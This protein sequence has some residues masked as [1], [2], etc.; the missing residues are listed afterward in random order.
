MQHNPLRTIQD[1]GQSIWQDFIRRK[2]ILSG[3]LK[4][5]IEQ[6][7][8]RGVTSNPAIFGKVIDGSRDYD[9]DI[10]TFA[11]QGMSTEEIY[12]A[13][14]VKDVQLAADLL[15]PVY[16][17]SDGQHGYVS[18][19]VN[20][21]L[22]RD[23]ER[24]L[25][26]ARRLW[27]T[28]QRPNV[29][30]KVPATE[31]GLTCIR[32]LIG[33]G[34]NINV[35]L[36]FGLPRYREVAEAYING[37]EARAA[38]KK[39]LEHIASVASFFLSRIDARIDP[40]LKKIVTEERPGKAK[41]EKLYGQVA[42]A[43]AKCAYKI[44]NDIFHSDRFNA[45]VQKG[46][47]PQHLL[48][49]STSTKD[50]EFSDV[51]Y[52]EALI[53]PDTINTLPRETLD[54]YRDHGRPARRL[55]LETHEAQK[56]LEH[57]AELD[58]NIQRVTQELVDQGI[59]KFIKPYDSSMHTLNKAR[60]AA[61]QAPVDRQILQVD[62]DCDHRIK[63]RIAR[64]EEEK[65]NQRLWNGDT[66]LWSHDADQSQTI[67]NGLGWLN[68]VRRMHD[69]L[70]TLTA[71]R[72]ELL[73]DG[74]RYV[75]HMGMGGS[76]LAPLVFQR[77]FSAARDG[78]TLLVLDSTDP[79]TLHDCERRL[80]LEQTFFI[81]ASK[82]GTTTEPIAFG[83]Y[84]YN[85]L[86][87]TMGDAAAWHFAVIT[88]PGTPLADLA[89]ERNYRRVFLN[90]SDI[91][92]RYSAL[93]YFGMLPAA[94][95][96]LDIR[97]MMVRAQRMV[98]ACAPHRPAGQSPGVVL[99]AA[100]GELAR[101][102]R[103]KVTFLVPPSLETLGMWLEQL[104]AESTGK[105]GTGL[106]PVAGEP[107][108][109]PAFYGDDRVFVHISPDNESEDRLARSVAALHDAGQPLITIRLQD[110]LDIAQEFFRWEVA[111]A[112]AGAVLG[113]N[114]FD[115]PN[116]QESKDNTRRLL[117]TVSDK[118]RLP[119]KTPD[120]TEGS[121]QLYLESGT[122][123]DTL[124]R[125]LADF[126]RQVRRGDYIAILAYL[127]EASAIDTLLAGI[128]LRLQQQFSTAVTV[129]YGPRYL[130][131]TGQFHKGGPNNGLFVQLTC[132]D[133]L[134]LN[135]PNRPFSFGV[136]RQ[137]QAQGD[138]EALS[139]HGRRAL[140]IHLGPDTARG[141]IRLKSIL[142]ASLTQSDRG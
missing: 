94:L 91:G 47:R 87:R 53:G 18:L 1:F 123:Q 43:S 11:L 68:L 8:I 20:P 138:L 22:A 55:D 85:R 82:S 104:L 118:G 137:A 121:L 122:A 133:T 114:A 127:T 2:M 49:A 88:D 113:I 59:D 99:G 12:E 119:E 15:R 131:S 105:A 115:Q 32:R 44:Y 81:V 14:T 134:N 72:N 130:H 136:L 9:D 79:A 140:R 71:F 50:P 52:V 101:Q 21:H 40:L 125:T 57:L 39:P 6:D 4:Q 80:P 77:S 65:F 66:E 132:D 112:T 16:D 84:F 103:D 70:D 19:E 108:F 46:A 69:D 76:S 95:M 116:V 120:L 75:V 106:L 28:L 51:K 109:P 35:T 13:L 25:N 124:T 3:E 62:D 93:S 135:I 78:L 102:G 117:E 30:I 27:D 31:K 97:E 60:T 34:I 139:K 33:E 86:M 41:A 36:L 64:L 83:E 74:F 100:L 5:F 110:R 90:F 26:E 63:R 141:L 92:G 67:T 61:L 73:D 89:R 29:M 111:T 23:V 24:T 129:G 10:S 107:P 96:G 45:L 58:I 7:G 128:R 17:R 98:R 48:W 37:L 142:E 126:F 54:A 42:I 38:A 56:I